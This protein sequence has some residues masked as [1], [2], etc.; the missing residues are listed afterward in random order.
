[1]LRGNRKFAAFVITI[2]AFV[3]IA[4]FRPETDLLSVGIGLT[5]ILGSFGFSNSMTH[6][7]YGRKETK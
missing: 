2:V 7:A 5:G 4:L 3:L 6:W 1:M